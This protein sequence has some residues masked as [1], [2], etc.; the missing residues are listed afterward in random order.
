MHVGKHLL[1][2]ISV[3]FLGMFFALAAC[4]SEYP[5]MYFL[6]IGVATTSTGEG[7]IADASSTKPG[8][9]PT[10][11]FFSVK[12]VSDAGSVF[13]GWYTAREHGALVSGENPY[14][15]RL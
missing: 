15:A 9:Y 1:S 7:S 5:A 13:T 12:A 11:T 4:K 6:D 8:V 3:A 10:G 14:Q 2:L